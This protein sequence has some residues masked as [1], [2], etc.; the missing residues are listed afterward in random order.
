MAELLWQ[1]SEAQIKKTNMFRF[2]NF[3]NETHNQNFNEYAPL[4]RWSVENIP[5]VW[6]AFW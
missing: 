2:M 5:E 3:I 6:A 4:Y 1:P